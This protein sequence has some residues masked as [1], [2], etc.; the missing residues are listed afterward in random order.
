MYNVSARY[1]TLGN[2]T[3]LS[4]TVDDGTNETCNNRLEDSVVLYSTDLPSSG[5]WED[6]IDT[7]PVSC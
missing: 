4:I 5:G 7:S 3:A 6:W 2:S 1:A